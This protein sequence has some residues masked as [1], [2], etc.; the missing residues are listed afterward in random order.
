MTPKAWQ[1][2]LEDMLEAIV[3]IQRYTASVNENTFF[4]NAQLLDAV[5]YNFIVLGEAATHIP[6][7]IQAR[8]PQVPW[9]DMRDMRNFLTHEYAKTDPEVLWQTIHEDVVPLVAVLEHI[10]VSTLDETTNEETTNDD[11]SA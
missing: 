11:P 1:V 7:D 10:L 6:A 9:R 4:T 8:Y 3:K 2:R 5:T